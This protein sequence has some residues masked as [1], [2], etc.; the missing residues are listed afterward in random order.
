MSVEVWPV[1]HLSGALSVT[2]NN[3]QIAQRCGCPGVFLI[4]M[5]GKDALIDPAADM[6]RREV[7]GLKIGINM[8]TE[9]P[10][11][12][13]LHSIA[14][15]YDATWS[16]YA[17]QVESDGIYDLCRAGHK[18][19]AAVAMKGETHD[20]ITPEVSALDA[21]LMGFVPMTSGSG[22]GV[23]APHDK[24]ERLRK[25]IGPDGPLA[26][27]GVHPPFER[28]AALTTHWLV[29]TAISSDFYHFDEAKLHA[30]V[31][32]AQGAPVHGT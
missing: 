28:L 32:H 19:F 14:M 15:G 8:L 23:P 22:T 18:F 2:L 10:L 6:I 13:V 4:S 25:A 7:P 30:L 16:D 21:Y 11:D 26:M 20:E 31:G 1:I 29:A 17:W 3:S 24:I 12:S 9:S 5:H 27:S